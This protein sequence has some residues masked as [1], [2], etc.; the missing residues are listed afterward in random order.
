VQKFAAGTG[1]LRWSRNYD[2]GYGGNDECYALAVTPEGDVV[3]AG[4]A[5]APSGENGLLTLKL[6]GVDGSVLW[7]VLEQGA[8]AAASA[9]HALAID[10]VGQIV[11]AG[12]RWAGYRN[13]GTGWDLAVRRYAAATGAEL[14]RVDRASAGWSDSPGAALVVQGDG[15][16]VAYLAQA[17]NMPVALTALKLALRP[18]SITAIASTGAS[19]PFGQPL[20]LTITVHGTAPTGLVTIREGAVPLAGCVNLT[21]IASGPGIASAGCVASLPIGQHVLVADY[22]GDLVNAPSSGTWTQTVAG[23][24]CAGFADIEAGD[25]FCANVDWI[26]NRGVTLGCASGLYCPTASTVR[27]AIA[28]SMNRLGLALTPRTV[29]VEAVTS[30]LDPDVEPI[31]CATPDHAVQDFPTSAT[32]DAVFAARAS[33]TTGLEVEPVASLDGGTTWAALSGQPP[34]ASAPAGHWRNVRAQGAADLEVGDVVR[35]ALRVRGVG[36]S[37]CTLTDSRCRVRALIR[38]RDGTASSR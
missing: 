5:Q 26:A 28:A 9:I 2:R 1:A 35:F 22:G 21:L 32:L 6:S 19:A 23:T 31:V 17:P 29:E 3:A 10:P 36:A 8:P 37:G 11:V 16:Y 20:A 30:T 7:S 13:N 33:A 38:S 27:L 24:P 34:R 14:W 25:P 15:I 18:A 12:Y 4:T